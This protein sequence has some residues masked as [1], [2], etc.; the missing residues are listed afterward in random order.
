MSVY[1][2]QNLYKNT[3][4]EASKNGSCACDYLKNETPKFTKPVGLFK[5]RNVTLQKV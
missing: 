4:I 3:V 1:T 5:K 2:W